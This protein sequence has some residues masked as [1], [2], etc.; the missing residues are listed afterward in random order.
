MNNHPFIPFHLFLS[1]SIF[2]Y[3]NLLPFPSDF[4]RCYLRF[5]NLKTQIVA[6]H[7]VRVEHMESK[8][9]FYR[10]YT[11][12]HLQNDPVSWE[13]RRVNGV[14]VVGSRSIEKKSQEK[15]GGVTVGVSR[16]FTVEFSWW[17]D[18][19]VNENETRGRERRWGS[20]TKPT[21]TSIAGSRPGNTTLREHPLPPPSLFP[22]TSLSD[23]LP[24]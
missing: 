5:K 8:N 23:L 7:Q 11:Y 9:E 12:I 21:I 19:T 3:T 18:L 13:K 6:T 4:Y 10:C 17:I 22:S 1:I 20:E 24:R 2:K 14:S 16:G 15:G